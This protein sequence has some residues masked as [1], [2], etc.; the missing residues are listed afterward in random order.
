[1]GEDCQPWACAA[2]G[3]ASLDERPIH[4]DSSTAAGSSRVTL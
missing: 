3:A 4:L 1:M 2:N